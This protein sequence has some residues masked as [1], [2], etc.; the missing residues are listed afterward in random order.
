M[1]SACTP[2][3]MIC[4]VCTRGT[5][6]CT[7]IKRVRLWTACIL[8]IKCCKVYFFPVAFFYA[9]SN[10][11][12]CKAKKPKAEWNSSSVVSGHYG[13]YFITSF[14]IGWFVCFPTNA[15]ICL[16]VCGLF[17]FAEFIGNSIYCFGF[18]SEITY[19]FY[20]MPSVNNW[21]KFFLR[22]SSC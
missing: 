7:Q 14:R 1:P 2:F 22:T 18:R 19:A 13:F 21:A 12:C 3:E 5:I 6:T 9:L 11:G 17:L 8:S 20:M 15:C 10:N 4:F 16:F